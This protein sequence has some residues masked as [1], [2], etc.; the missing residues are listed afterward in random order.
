[1]AKLSKM[2]SEKKSEVEKEAQYKLKIATLV[3]VAKECA[4]EFIRLNPKCNITFTITNANLRFHIDFNERIAFNAGFVCDT[5]GNAYAFD[6]W[7][8]NLESLTSKKY[9]DLIKECFDQAKD[10]TEVSFLL[11]PLSREFQY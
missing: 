1:M 2:I 3:N 7:F 6:K 10:E 5:H 9:S 4:R 8:K 11:Y